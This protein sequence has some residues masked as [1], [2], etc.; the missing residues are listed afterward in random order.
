MNAPILDVYTTPLAGHTL[1]EAS[2]GTG[3]TW[4]ISGLYTRLLLDPD[5]N[6]QVSE[7]LV[8][9]FTTAAT[10]ELRERIRQRLSDVL[11]SFRSGTAV[12]EFCARLLESC[13]GGRDWA[14][15]KLTRA[16]A[17]FD[18]AAI[19]TIHGFC[20]RILAEAAFESG[21]DFGLQMLPDQSELLNEVVEDYW[22]QQVYPASGAW[23]D[24]LQ[25]QQ[26]APDDWRGKVKPFIG[27]LQH[28]MLPLLPLADV[29]AE[30]AQFDACLA[31]IDE[32]WRSHGGALG[33]LLLT[34]PG[35]SR[36][37]YRVDTLRGRLQRLDAL[38]LGG[39]LGREALRG[40]K[41]REEL[42]KFAAGRLAAAA[43]KGCAPLQH[44]L[45]D[46]IERLLQ[47]AEALLPAFELRLQHLLA[48]LLQYIERELPRR[49][50]ERQQLS[51]DDLLTQVWQAT[52][53][54][55]GPHFNQFVRSRYRAALIDEFQDTDPVQCGIFAAL[56]GGTGLP[57]FFVGDPKQAIYSFRGADIHAYLAARRSVDRSATLDTNQRSVPLLIRAVNTLFGNGDNP[58]AF[59]D[60]GIE[61]QPV[62]APQKQRPSLQI[63]GEAAAPL[64]FLLLPA[65]IGKKGE[66]TR[67]ATSANALAAA[68]TANEIARLLT[69]AAQGQAYIDEQGRQRPLSGGDIAVLVPSGWLAQQM[70]AE[71]RLRGI[72]SVRQVRDSVFASAEA[73]ALLLVLQ[74]I[75]APTRQGLV[76][77]ALVAPLLGYDI[78]TLQQAMDAGEPWERLLDEFSRWH[79]LWRDAGF[80][81]MLRDWL[82][83]P[84]AGGQS[85][86]QR[87][88]AL[89]DGE[90]RLTN[91]LHLAE[92][93]QQQSRLRVGIEPLLIWL[94][95]MLADPQAGGDAALMRLESDAE[96]VQIVTIHSSKG[97]EYPVVFCPWLFD[98][99][100]GADGVGVSFHRDDSAWL[101]FG[102]ARL[103]EHRRIAARE[104]LAE[105]LRL[106]YVALTRAKHRCYVVWGNVGILAAAPQPCSTAD[107]IARGLHS[108]PLSWLLHPCPNQATAD[109][110]LLAMRNHCATLDSEAIKHD[111]LQL[112]RRAP[113][114]IAILPLPLPDEPWR[115]PPPTELTTELQPAAFGRPPLQWGWRVASFSGLTRETLQPLPSEQLE[116]PDHDAVAL[117]EPAA[118]APSREPSLFNFPLGEVPAAV[119]GTTIHAVLEHWNWDRPDDLPALVERELAAAGL[120]PHW[121]PVVEQFARHSV[122]TRLDRRNLTLARATAQQRLAEM[123]F[124]FPLQGLSVAA[125]QKLLEAPQYGVD[126]AFVAASKLLS[127]DSLQGYL[128]GFIDLVFEVDGR[129]YIVDYKTNRLGDRAADYGPPQL[130]QA[131][132]HSHY[133]LQYLIYSV[134]LHLHL[135][136][137]LP[138]YA[139][140]SHFGGVYYLFLR[141][142]ADE[143]GDTGV[144]FD[145]PPLALIEAFVAQIL[146]GR[147]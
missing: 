98:G 74:A 135:Q 103:G 57:L 48:G 25:L 113:D 95:H 2:A 35:L 19:F 37:S 59:V 78:N 107:A 45:F 68:G 100:L 131:V 116:A 142:M 89:A 31:Q 55:Q 146:G 3:K 44:P 126:P 104:A 109:D 81:R 83:W 32:L 7:I 145:R 139:Y 62:R 20:Q 101:D 49:K 30:L 137:R 87:L 66:K 24:Y 26:A 84:G 63:D 123:E 129:Y 122:A 86:P 125:V 8:V 40:G 118:T 10:A 72:A 99:K 47:L 127:F 13:G 28:R 115:A 88:L 143:S 138:G 93:L 97:L 102:S 67:S 1:I 41:A 42:E 51:F 4:T 136:A 105:K 16:V 140:A 23:L 17:G 38:I 94:Q 80:M 112:Q 29:T 114:A 12:D 90:R 134:A 56:Y 22:R 91:L 39:A 133:Y 76:R 147:A 71:L 73:Q 119:A 132:A 15:R 106:L 121:Q 52:R 61:F 92:L 54:P 6:L 58:A 128:R 21:A 33:E 141:G 70:Q 144:F 53:G 117:P 64:R 14:V 85:V 111:L 110:P 75:A 50:Q 43:K 120:Q 124:T 11:D 77:T 65:E 82:D 46:A 108:S 36:Q 60:T 34:D 79:Q 5:L 9:T 27:N 69:L 130:T 96:R 18:D